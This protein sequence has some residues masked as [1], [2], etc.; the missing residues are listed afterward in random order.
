MADSKISG[1]TVAATLVDARFAGY[2][3]TDTE[4]NYQFSI[5]LL[6]ARYYTQGT[7][8]AAS[9]ITSG[10]F[11]NGR[12]AASNVTQHAGSISHSDLLASSLLNDDHPNLHNDARGDARY[13]TQTQLNGNVL[14]SLY[15]TQSEV[16]SLIAATSGSIAV[17]DGAVEVIGVATTLNFE[18]AGVTVTDGG[19]DTAVVTIAP[20]A[21]PIDTV[22]GRTGAVVAVSGDYTADQ[23]TETAT[24][25]IMTDAER[26]KLTGI[27]TAATADQ[28]S[29]EILAA[30]ETQTGRTVATDGAKLD[31]IEASADVTDETNVTAALSGATLTGAGTPASDDK[32]LIQDTSDA[33]N[34]KT[35]AVSTLPGGGTGNTF[36]TFSPS[37]GDD[38]VAD[39]SADTVNFAAGAGMTITGTAGTDTL[40]FTAATGTDGFTVINL[41]EGSGQAAANAT[42]LTNAFANGGHYIID[43]GTFECNSVTLPGNLDH[44]ITTRGKVVFRQ[45]SSASP[46]YYNGYQQFDQTGVTVSA[47]ATVYDM[48]TSSE[49]GVTRFTVSNATGFAKGSI[50]HISST[51]TCTIQT[52]ADRGTFFTVAHVSGNYVYAD[53]IV[54]VI[55]NVGTATPTIRRVTDQKSLVIEGDITFE[56]LDDATQT[57]MS[58]PVFF[59]FYCP[60]KARIKLRG[61]DT[62]STMFRG[63]SDFQSV[64]DIDAED[65][66]VNYQISGFAYGYGLYL[67]A[68]CYQST[69]TVRAHSIGH[70]VVQN[71]MGSAS[72]WYQRG[73]PSGCR[74]V[75]SVM[76]GH[77]RSPLDIHAAINPHFDNC[78]AYGMHE[79]PTQGV[80]DHVV[81]DAAYNLVVS[82]CHFYGFSS[83]VQIE[84]KSYSGLVP[85]N[86][87][88]TKLHN[89]TAVCKSASG[90]IASIINVISDISD[91]KMLVVNGGHYQ[92]NQAMLFIHKAIRVALQGDV[93]IRAP[94]VASLYAS[95]VILEVHGAIF[96]ATGSTVFH[97]Q[98]S[99]TQCLVSKL[100]VSSDSTSATANVFSGSGTGLTFK[101]EQ[102][103]MLFFNNSSSP[104]LGSGVIRTSVPGLP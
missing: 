56:A 99:G 74:V 64:W 37:S 5:D 16:T 91:G 97:N 81:R 83:V 69:A 87:N 3:T 102:K 65:S 68:A 86:H 60:I 100:V 31:A 76:S 78:V 90:G 94:Q 82:N 2:I 50:C 61:R 92:S 27:E 25:K 45:P 57:S 36:A 40:T 42:A 79:N 22:F 55:F 54:P 30:W 72:L 51:E 35:V 95:G 98:T 103:N 8:L 13:Y 70:A 93:R 85:D 6:D 62:Y 39:S 46:W 12:V 14:G 33:D 7:G 75:N 52:Y 59:D 24:G 19:D 89:V 67:L 49:V 63:F 71:S 53:H 96:S 4:N 26:T 101:C 32:I 47:I 29:A 17:Q 41:T 21:A 11:D 77:C 28:T 10:T 1:F 15:Y 34:L 58:R 38:V 73:I 88:I 23:I 104:G 66:Y 44:Y 9:N 84:S 80:G 43:G 18:G 48:P 20:G